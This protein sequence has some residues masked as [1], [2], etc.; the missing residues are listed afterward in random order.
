MNVIKSIATIVSFLILSFTISG[1][2]QTKQLFTS[3]G[4]A[5]SFLQ[6][7][8]NKYQEN[9]HP[10]YAFDN[11]AKTAWVEGVDGDGI[12]E[13]LHWKT[14][15]L[16]DVSKIVLK[17]R[18]GYQKSKNLFEANAT[19][20]KIKI[21]LHDKGGKEYYEQEFDLTKSMGWQSVEIQPPTSTKGLTGLTLKILEVYPGKTYKDTC[22]SDIET[23]VESKVPYDEVAEKQKFKNLMDWKKERLQAARYFANLP[24]SFPAQSTRFSSAESESIKFGANDPTYSCNL[25]PKPTIEE[26]FRPGSKLFSS[27]SAITKNDVLKRVKDFIDKLQPLMKEEVYYKL[28]FSPSALE[29]RAPDFEVRTPLEDA[30]KFARASEVS[31]FE[32]NKV[33]ASISK[34]NWSAQATSNARLSF[35][36]SE[37]KKLKALLFWEKRSIQERG[38]YEYISIYAFEYDE[39]GRLVRFAKWTP[40]KAETPKDSPFPRFKVD[41]ASWKLD[42]RIGSLMT[43]VELGYNKDKFDRVEFL[44]LQDDEYDCQYAY[45]DYFVF[46]AASQKV[47]A[48]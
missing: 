26:I 3:G 23:I 22:I 30:M 24:A 16:E 20:K 1:F 12:G 44:D 14:S 2:S 25:K 31:F 9:Y 7:N 32:A 6:S 42:T 39:S 8:W 27:D 38:L 11:D 15:K 45:G 41:S 4:E 18:N 19:P 21:F 28:T 37:K 17:I 47:A 34:T 36:D 5:T 29:W 46:K 10:N 43:F 40:R 48:Q 13:S 35:F 33:I